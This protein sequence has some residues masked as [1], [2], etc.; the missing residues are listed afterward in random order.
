MTDTNITLEPRV[1]EA[2]RQLRDLPDSLE[3]EDDPAFTVEQI[4]FLE[5]RLY[6]VRALLEGEDRSQI[7]ADITL[8]VHDLLAKHRQIAAIWA[9]ED[10]KGI[11]PHLTDD[12]AWEVLERVRD[13]HDAEW[14]ITWTTLES[15]ADDLFPASDE[16]DQTAGE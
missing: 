1:R 14:G 5:K 9:I 16:S 4:N 3:A 2:F 7:Y 10:I 13:K 6:E 8:Y 12:Q 11:R 15:V